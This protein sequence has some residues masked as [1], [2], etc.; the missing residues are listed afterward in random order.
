MEVAI[1][2]VSK[3]QQKLFGMVHAC[4][5]NGSC[6]SPKI[7]KIAHSIKFKDAKDFASTKHK[8]LPEKVGKKISEW[9]FKN[10]VEYRD[11]EKI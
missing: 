11:N 9:S 3:A 7:S 6:A 4:Q 8:G 2:S 10:Y 5:K 1:P